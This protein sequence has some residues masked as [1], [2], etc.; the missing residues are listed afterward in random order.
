MHPPFQ[1]S[2]RSLFRLTA[3][4]AVVLGTM[5]ALCRT[6]S[7][8]AMGSVHAYLAL[9]PIAAVWLAWRTRLLD[10]RRLMIIPLVLYVT[11]LALPSLLWDGRRPMFGFIA[12][13]NSFVG[14]T[15][16]PIDTDEASV[17]PW[18]FYIKFDARD[19][20]ACCMGLISNVAFLLILL[21]MVLRRFS[22]RLRTYLSWSAFL[23]AM[24]LIIPLGFSSRL[25][26]IYI[27]YGMWVAAMLALWLRVRELTID[28]STSADR[29]ET[30]VDDQPEVSR[31][32][33]APD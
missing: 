2:L 29:T 7:F 6:H 3:V 27:G 17:L 26:H 23:S 25:D 13:C 21:S 28:P 16:H 19:W 31:N 10:G 22:Q 11:S 18:P 33:D 4:V 12:A 30:D 20:L 24:L 8:R 9:V 1:F 14:V 32:R 15:V 5:T